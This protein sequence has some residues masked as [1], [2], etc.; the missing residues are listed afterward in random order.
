VSRGFDPSIVT[1][2]VVA[3]SEAEIALADPPMKLVLS[4][5]DGE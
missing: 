4:R 5:V 1:S 2:A 3:W